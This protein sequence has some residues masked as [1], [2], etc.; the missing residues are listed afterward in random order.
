MDK[1]ISDQAISNSSFQHCNRLNLI[2]NTTFRYLIRSLNHRHLISN[3]ISN[4]LIDPL[5]SDQASLPPD[6]WIVH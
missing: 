2:L 3:H 1:L 4:I 5:T 6:K